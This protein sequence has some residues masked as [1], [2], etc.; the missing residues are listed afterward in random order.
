MSIV[1]V[2]TDGVVT[3]RAHR[4]SDVQRSWEQCQDPESIRWTSVPVPYSHADAEEFLVAM[5][6]GWESDAEWAFAVEYAGRYAGTVSLRN[7]RSRRAEIAYGSHPDVRGVRVEGPGGR[8]SVMERA[9]RLL[10]DW[11]FGAR[12]L[13]TVIWWA[14]RGNWA[15]R[16]LAWRLGFTVEGTVR[17]WQPQRGDLRDAWVGTLRRGD[18]REPATTWLENPLVAGEGLVLRPF[19]ADDA[20]RIVEGLAD[21]QTQHWL[22]FLPRDPGPGAGAAFLEEVTERLASAHT[23]TWAVSE[24]PDGPLLG[25]MGLYRLVAGREAE[26]GYW[27]H[28]EG[29][30]RGLTTR[31]A[32]LALDHAFRALGLE[33]VTAWAAAPNAASLGVLTAL[34]MRRVGTQR[35]AARTGSAE[36]VDLV[37]FDLLA[38]EW[39]VRA[40]DVADVPRLTG[41]RVVLRALA[42]TDVPRIVEACSDERT[43]HWLGTMPAPY[44]LADA[45][46]WIGRT[47]QWAAEGSKLHWAIADPETDLLVGAVNLFDLDRGFEGEIGYWTHPDARGRGVMTE[48]ARLAAAYAFDE[49]GLRVLRGVAA[50]DNAASRHVLESLGMRLWGVERL[51]TIV[52]TGPT[53]AARYDVTAQEYAGARPR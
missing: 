18:P 23:I 33:R 1:P 13:E 12:S 9:L 39:P 10:L 29:R 49:L 38:S 36:T 16:R 30:G 11:G 21:A 7:E 2:L 27:T 31:A 44:S 48:A 15:S 43:Q 4:P 20:E 53:D 35:A 6:Q 22:A 51:G 45:V 25:I 40:A 3:L 24:T 34:G 52:R 14:E 32:R 41:E 47:R 50:V 37:G 5:A 17:H 28:A 42:E 46:A 26:I 19:R 8:K